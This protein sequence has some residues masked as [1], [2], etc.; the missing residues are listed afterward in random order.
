MTTT[1]ATGA[2]LV[3]ATML[4]VMLRERQ[5]SHRCTGNCLLNNELR[6]LRPAGDDCQDD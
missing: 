2:L 3:M 1:S 4:P 6:F 5:G